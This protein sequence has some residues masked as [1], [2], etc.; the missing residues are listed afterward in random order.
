M[1]ETL[2]SNL[3]SSTLQN[4]NEETRKLGVCC[5]LDSSS[6]LFVALG[7][8]LSRLAS[9]SDAAVFSAK[10]ESHFL[11]VWIIFLFSGS[12]SFAF[13]V[14]KWIEFIS[15][16]HAL[17]IVIGFF[18]RR[19]LLNHFW[20]MRKILLLCVCVCVWPEAFIWISRPLQA[21]CESKF[22]WKIASFIVYFSLLS[23]N[24]VAFPVRKFYPSNFDFLL[25]WIAHSLSC[26]QRI[27]AV[28]TSP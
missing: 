25:I 26:P 12:V 3:H 10:L 24:F 8:H 20:L 16:P 21:I 19:L 15:K 14:E 22:L 4:F 5:L 27:L 28:T 18:R 13:F 23:W 11:I 7:I 2:L 17:R 1:L 9:L 6:K